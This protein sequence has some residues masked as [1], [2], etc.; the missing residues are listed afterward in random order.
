MPMANIILDSRK[1]MVYED[2]KYLC[3]FSSK[4]SDFADSLWGELQSKPELYDEFVYYLDH[5]SLKDKLSVKGYSLTDL[6]VYNIGKYNLLNDF[7]KNTAICNKEGMVLNCFWGMAR[8]M[9][10]PDEIIKKLEAGEG[11]D[12]L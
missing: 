3:D 11:M 7:G 8:L 6:Y 9:D 5:H 10:N 1:L 2:L 4:S 12:K